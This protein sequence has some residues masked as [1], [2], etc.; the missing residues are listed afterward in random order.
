MSVLAKEISVVPENLLQGFTA[1]H[2]ER[3]WRPA[4]RTKSCQEQ[5]LTRVLHCRDVSFFL[6]LLPSCRLV[7]GRQR[8][9]FAPSFSNNVFCLAQ[10][11]SVSLGLKQIVLSEVPPI[12]M[13]GR[14]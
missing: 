7:K 14:R 2:P 9:S 3:K 8:R 6:T 11:K 12:W 1:E 13:R 4:L 10:Q 5:A